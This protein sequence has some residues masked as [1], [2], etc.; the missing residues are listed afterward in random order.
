MRRK[1]AIIGLIFFYV[2]IAICE[3]R[4]AYAADVQNDIIEQQESALNVDSVQQILN[5]INSV[6]SDMPR[7]NIKELIYDVIN[8]KNIIDINQV[9]SGGIKMVFREISLNA[10]LLA[11]IIALSV[12][13][14]LLVNLQHSFDGEAIGQIAFLATYMVIIILLLNSFKASMDVGKKAIDQMVNFM[15]A[16][17][18]TLF[19]AMV[20][21]GSTV[22]V[23]AFSPIIAFSVEGI[24]AIIRDYIM[25]L[26][27]W[28]SVLSLVS[29]LNTKVQIDRCISFMKNI[30]TTVIVLLPLMLVG[31]LTVEGVTSPF[32]DNAAIKTAKFATDKFIP[33]VGGVISD[34]V[35]AILR[36]MVI[37]KNSIGVV[38]MLAVVFIAIYPLVKMFALLVILKISAA[39]IQPI[40]DDKVVKGLE[41]VAGSLVLM[42]SCVVVVAVMFFISLAILLAATSFLRV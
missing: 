1:I 10:K 20:S 36:Y 29:N 12:I 34:T 6:N 28:V 41:G 42:I 4:P 18:P 16:L 35:D 15:Q 40:T 27:Y 37:L 33:V 38:G 9:L 21:S 22:S 5:E 24:S 19:A 39:F 30:I 3:I 26:I 25:P 2:L 32:V 11:Q 13:C 17:M 31:V 7:L 23:A 14:A 8:G